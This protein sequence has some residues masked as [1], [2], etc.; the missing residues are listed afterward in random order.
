M[1]PAHDPWNTPAML[2]WILLALIM[3]GGFRSYAEPDGPVCQTQ[4]IAAVCGWGC[5]H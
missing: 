4:V 2:S 5:P 3:I 1:Q